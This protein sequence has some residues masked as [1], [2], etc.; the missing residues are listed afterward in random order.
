MRASAVE[1]S[2]YRREPPYHPPD[3]ELPESEERVRHLGSLVGAGAALATPRAVVYGVT[4]DILCS[5]DPRLARYSLNVPADLKREAEQFARL[6]G[7]SLNQFIL[8]AVSEKVG[9]LKQGLDDPEFP[10][11]SYRR[12]TSGVPAPVVRGT[13]VRV[14]SIVIAS[15]D[16]R[17]APD[18]IAEEYDLPVEQAL[19]F[20]EAHREEISAAIAREESMEEASDRS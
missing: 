11:I 9:A 20:Y 13:G 2:P 1:I 16:W 4:Y 14:Q 18:S 17:L 12:G 3:V 5:E 19:A 10:A 8:W 6:Q 15:R 7:V